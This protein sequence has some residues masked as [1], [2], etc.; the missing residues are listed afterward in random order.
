MTDSR[1]RELERRFRATGTDAD[2]ARLL[3]ERVRA[4]GLPGER[5]RL[6]AFC[7]H[8]PARLALGDEAPP[9]APELGPWLLE[10]EEFGKEALVRAALA[11]AEVALDHHPAGRRSAACLACLETARAWLRDPDGQHEAPPRSSRALGSGQGFFVTAPVMATDAAHF[12]AAAATAAR[13]APHA[14]EAVHWACRALIQPADTE[15]YHGPV[16]AWAHATI[17]SAIEAALV[18]WSLGGSGR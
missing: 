11:A 10:L 14:T 1:R 2:A 9:A 6:A 17:R 15:A 16:D 8:G 13:P 7:G 3:V 18:A 4:G 5:V 12:A